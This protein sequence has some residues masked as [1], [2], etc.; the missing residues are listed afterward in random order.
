M[1]EEELWPNYAA[2]RVWRSEPE[3]EPAYWTVGEP[4]S[5]SSEAE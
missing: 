4:V 2:E 3:V 5:N 1:E